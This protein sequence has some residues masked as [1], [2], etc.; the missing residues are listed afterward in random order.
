MRLAIFATGPVGREVV[1]IT[2]ELAPDALV[3][4]GLDAADDSGGREEIRTAARPG[5]AAVEIGRRPTPEVESALAGADL[6]LIVLAWWPYIV[7]DSVLGLPRIGCLNFH[8]SLLPHNR[9]KDPNFWALVE[10]RPY[11]VTLHFADS[12][13]DGGDI[14]Y[15]REVPVT[16]EDTG[17]TLYRRGQAA[18]VDLYRDNLAQIVAGDVPRR[19]QP[20][21]G[22]YHRRSDLEAGSQLGL[23]SAT[24]GRAV[25]NLLRAR[26]FPPHPGAWFVDE[27]VRYQV[28][29]SIERSDE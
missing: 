14:A 19:K 10:Q 1:R 23:D 24:T 9:G 2:A 17:E 15:Q 25:L 12:S 20:S 11:G 6:D 16:W 22:S 27:G 4:V 5:T 7:P 3:V 8:P 28:R 18:I 21:G 13:T 29:L 26:T